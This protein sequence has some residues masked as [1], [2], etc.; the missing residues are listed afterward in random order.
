[1][2]LQARNASLR[3]HSNRGL[4]CLRH[5]TVSTRERQVCH[6]LLHRESNRE[7]ARDLNVSPRTVEIHRMKMMDKIG[8][9]NLAEAIRRGWS[10]TL[11]SCP[12]SIRTVDPGYV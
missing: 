5:G 8:A 4:T 1:M 12:I 3:L 7:I 11:A 9:R 10:A 6:G 2:T